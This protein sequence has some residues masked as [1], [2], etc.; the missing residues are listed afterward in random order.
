MITIILHNSALELVN[1]K[2]CNSSHK[3][4]LN[5]AKRRKKKP[6]ELLLDITV[7]QS[8]MYPEKVHNSGRPDLVHLF[9]LQYHHIMKLL[10]EQ[11]SNIKLYVHTK[12]DEVFYVPQSWR[13]P[14]HFIR[15]RGLM[16]KF[17]IEKKI[18]LSQTEQLELVQSNLQELIHQL[19]PIKIINLT[20]QGSFEP[21]LLHEIQNPSS[22]NQLVVLIGGYQR[23]EDNISGSLEKQ[24]INL[25]LIDR[26][27]TAWMILN[28]LYSGKTLENK[29]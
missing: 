6:T 18:I 19:N 7:H 20:E 3:A 26:P 13:V 11:C 22:S 1:E 23:G 16:E 24:I 4:I 5:D 25:K 27:T 14:V 17:L 2:V 10:P 21:E 12:N 15:F 28:I 29:N 8:A 9:L